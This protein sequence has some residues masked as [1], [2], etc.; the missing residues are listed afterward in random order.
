MQYILNKFG[1]KDAKP[2]K[3][4]MGINIHPDLNIGCKS[5][6]QKAYQS[7][8]GSLPYLC[9]SR[10]NIMFLFACVQGSNLILRNVTLDAL[11]EY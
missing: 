3:T 2:I 5:V 10:P 1:M 4:L 9:A 11:R 7:M 8:I 6:D